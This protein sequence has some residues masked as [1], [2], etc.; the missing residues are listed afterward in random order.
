GGGGEKQ[1]RGAGEDCSRSR[2]RHGVLP[3]LRGCRFGTIYRTPDVTQTAP[4]VGCF[5]ALRCFRRGPHAFTAFSR[6]GATVSPGQREAGR[7]PQRFGDRADE[8]SRCSASWMKPIPRFYLI[9]S[10]CPTY[11]EI[12]FR[13]M[14]AIGIATFAC[15][16][17]GYL[18]KALSSARSA[19]WL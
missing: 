9:R 14:I 2:A 6:V 12:L 1:D 8:A 3:D 5:P 10:L 15:Q 11:W 16:K 17:G 7:P 4:H 13:P 18:M 19:L